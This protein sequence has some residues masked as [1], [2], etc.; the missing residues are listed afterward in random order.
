[1]AVPAF[2]LATL[3]KGTKADLAAAFAALETRPQ[4][5]EVIG[6]LDE[7]W[8]NPYGHVIGLTGPPG[9]GKSSLVNALV[10]RWRAKGH[11]IGIIAVD[12]TSQ[13]SGGA[14]LGDRIRIDAAPDEGV[15][16]RSM[17]ARDQIGGLAALTAATCIVMRAIYDRVIVE[18]VGIGQSQTDIVNLADT[19]VVCVQPGS[20]DSL[21][22]M[23]AGIMEVPHVAVV[24]KADLGISAS[25]ALADVEGALSLS[26][27]GD[28]WGVRCLALSAVTGAG[29][30]AFDETIT[31]H[32]AF[33]KGEGA[34]GR[35]RKK[36]GEALLV[37]ALKE[38]YGR[39][40]LKRAQPLIE[41]F[42]EGSPFARAVQIGEKLSAAP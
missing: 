36:Q 25:R 13:L 31:A 18:T 32:F 4:S 8:E 39:E 2:T 41:I 20:G 33:L 27:A 26:V 24:S 34:L 11:T 19:V 7:A 38:A 28:G 35:Q 40:G 14:L 15:F 10:K 30:E 21:Q 6:L 29:L 16:I 3:K 9:V 17:A 37:A 22:F 5:A 23:K 1:M 42:R 12:P